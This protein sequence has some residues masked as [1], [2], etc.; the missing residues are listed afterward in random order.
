MFRKL[1]EAL[2]GEIKS[3][4]A[5]AWN[6]QGRA[7][8]GFNS[9]ELTEFHQG[10]KDLPDLKE[11]P[12]TPEMGATV[13][14]KVVELNEEG[15]AKEVRA[16]FDPAHSP[17][18]AEMEKSQRGMTFCAILGPDEFLVQQGTY[19]QETTTWHIRGKKISKAARLA[20][21]AWS[22][23]R[24]HFLTVLPDG[25]VTLAP[26]YGAEPVQ[27][28]MV[29]SGASFVPADL[30]DALKDA[31]EAP[32]DDLGLSHVAVSDD[33]SKILLCDANRGVVLLYKSGSEWAS[34]L[35]YPAVHL[36]LVEDMREMLQEDEEYRP[37][38]DMLHATLSPDGRFV[39]VGH[40]SDGHHLVDIQDPASPKTYAMLGH[41]SEYPHDAC[42]SDDSGQVAFNSCHFYNG[43]TFSSEINEVE[44]LE[45]SLGE[46]H[47]SQTILNSYLRVYASGFVPASMTLSAEEGG[48]LL[49]GSGFTNCVTADGQVLWEMEHGSSAG[50][51]DV[52]PKTGQVLLASYSGFLHLLDPKEQ[53]DPPL[54]SGYQAPTEKRRWIFWDQL[55]QPLIW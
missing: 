34:Q 13:L 24:Q 20:A 23:N 7:F 38:L 30:P 3:V 16:M 25:R 15:R 9:A 12:R 48:F 27:D 2:V 46:Q 29:V 6:A 51:V 37:W 19:Y 8:A 4:D 47:K 39:A 17:F 21:F 49:A 36:S 11:D 28:V 33:G 10:R 45:T 41:L 18:I 50:G 52:C 31:F 53:Q 54:L 14:S 35:I 32:R 43:I 26:G 44:G 42:F 22:R 40:Q 1:L 5:A 55:E